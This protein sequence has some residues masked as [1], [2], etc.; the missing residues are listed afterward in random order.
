MDLLKYTSTKLLVIAFIG[1]IFIIY[2]NIASL[3]WELSFL[4]ESQHFKHWVQFFFRYL[5]FVVFIWF[6]LRYNLWKIK[7]LPFKNRLFK[8]LLISTLAFVLFLIVIYFCFTKKLHFSM[9]LF[10]FSVVCIICTF[11]G[12]VSLLYAEQIKREQEIERLKTENLQSRYDALTN[13]INP[14]F[15][16]NSLNGLSA[17]IRKKDDIKTQEYVNTLSDVFRYILQSGKKGLVSLSEELNFIYS[18]Q[19]MMEVRFANKL[20]FEIEVAEEKLNLKIPVLSLLPLI[21]NIV[22]HNTIDSEHKMN[23]HICLN[24]RDELVVSNPVYPKLI[25]PETNGTGLKNLENRFALLLN[26]QIRVANDDNVF[27]VY[28]PLA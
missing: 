10:Q 24:E 13:Q 16:F 26:K 22:V 14:H 8:T 21:D 27:Y 19:Y 18:F 11:V 20:S 5:F 28:L 9:A 4:D 6:L 3:P 12:H 1:A 15:F 2:P 17:L 7:E 23:I 25:Q